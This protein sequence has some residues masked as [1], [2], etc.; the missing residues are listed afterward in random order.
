MC[1]MCMCVYLL[2]SRLCSTSATQFRLRVIRAMADLTNAAL[3]VVL[4][5]GVAPEVRDLTLEVERL[6]ACLAEQHAAYDDLV[7]GRLEPATGSM[8]AAA[9]ELSNGRTQQRDA[10]YDLIV[11]ALRALNGV[12]GVSE[13]DDMDDTDDDI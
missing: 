1:V 7:H 2:C 10:A 9:R 8:L 5:E 11:E 13:G 12:S 4:G 6:H 3:R